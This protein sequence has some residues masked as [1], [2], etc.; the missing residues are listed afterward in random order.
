MQDLFVLVDEVL[1]IEAT[2]SI[3]SLSNFGYSQILDAA[4]FRHHLH[5]QSAR[6]LSAPRAGG[7]ARPNLA[8]EGLGTAGLERCRRRAVV[9]TL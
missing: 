8:A 4:H 3:E 5:A 7:V 6:G 9:G 2:I 1:A